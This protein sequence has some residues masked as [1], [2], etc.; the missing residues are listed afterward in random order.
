MIRTKATTLST[1]N[2]EASTSSAWLTRYRMTFAVAAG[3]LM[4]SGSSSPLQAATTES[5]TTLHAVRVVRETAAWTTASNVWVD[6]PGA[7]TTFLV[8][9][10]HTDLY[11][12]RF[13]S[14]SACWGAAGWCSVRIL[15]NNLEMDPA[16]GADYAFDSSG[17]ASD[18]EGHSVER[19]KRYTGTGSL[20]AV[21]TLKVQ[22]RLSAAGMRFRLDDWQFT[23]KQG[24]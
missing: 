3:I 6:V 23:V 18:F 8:A 22:V 16:S 11:T 2:R 7:T 17:S 5:L 21:V 1:G 4:V 20:F 13:T 19:S 24:H 10:G 9:S 15:V 14:E 12:A